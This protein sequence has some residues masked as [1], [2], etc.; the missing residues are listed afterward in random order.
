MLTQDMTIN[1]TQFTAEIAAKPEDIQRGMHGRAELPENHGLCFM[2]PVPTRVSV[3]SANLN[4]NLDAGFF[5]DDAKLVEIVKIDRNTHSEVHSEADNV[6]FML[7]IEE[8]WFENNNIKLGDSLNM[9]VKTPIWMC[10]D[11]MKLM[12]AEVNA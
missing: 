4:F 12:P 6:Q 10:M 2:L 11:M 7:E 8:N 5:D 1:D 9:L 3:S